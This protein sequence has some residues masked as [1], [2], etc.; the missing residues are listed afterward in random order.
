MSLRFSAFASDNPI[1]RVERELSRLV[2]RL[3]EYY[4]I[5]QQ[6]IVNEVRI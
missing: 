4:E 2:K 5:S 3:V 1:K 6:H